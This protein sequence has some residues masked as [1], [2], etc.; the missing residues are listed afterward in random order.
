MDLGLKNKV[1]MVAGASK[2]LGFAV[3]S[4][5]AAEG[6][7]VS[8]ASRNTAAIQEAKARIR[9]TANV[10]VLACT[11]DVTSPGALEQWRDDTVRE[12]GGVDLLFVNSGG[13]PAG[14]FAALTDAQWNHAV[15]LL[16]MSSVRLVR[17]VLPSLRSRGGGSIVFS[18]S[19]SVREPIENLV[20]SNVVR[21]TLPALAKT[22][23]RELAPDHIRVNSLMPGRIETD[24]VRE[25][26]AGAAKKKG[27][28]EAEQKAAML[29]QI[30]LGRYGDPDEYARAAVFLLSSA[31]SYITGVTLQVDGGAIKSVY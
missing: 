14:T 1:A 31:S 12:F 28:T 7:L 4:V 10:E 22:L 25:L 20:L 15:E 2:G 17:S 23:A 5:L 19:T 24:R 27:I 9:K 26:D 8:M 21:A 16:L 6:A 3:A 18:T 30:P 29:A 11:A 13:P